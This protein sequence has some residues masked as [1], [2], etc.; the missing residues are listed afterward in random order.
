VGTREAIVAALVYLVAH[1]CYK[2]ALFLVA[3]IIDHETGGRDISSLAAL[4]RPMP[5]TAFAGGAAALSMAGVPLTL[6]F[7]GKDGAY[8]ALQHAPDWFPWPLALLVLVSILLGVAG[9]LAGVLPFW[10][11]GIPSSDAHDP[12]W[13]LWLP[14][15]ILAGCGLVAGVAPWLLDGPLTAAA[16]AAAGAPI[17]VSLSVWHGVTPALLLSALTLRGRR[18]RV[19]RARRRVEADVARALRIGG[20]L[21]RV[22]RGAR[23][24]RPDD[25]PDAA[26]RV[27]ADVRHG[28]R[29]HDGADRRLGAG[30]GSAPRLGRA[31]NAHRDPRRPRRRGHHRR[32]RSRRRWRGRRWRPSSRSGP[33]AMASP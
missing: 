23:C 1:A 28:D 7:A 9:L 12:A 8:E 21:H 32:A 3:G 4:R 30:A 19:C 33:W 11:R 27:A 25:R 20:R 15:T 2:G 5:I 16:R 24:D 18:A 17:D 29:G 13:P 22:D 6:G 10:R 26:Q 14:P 31:A